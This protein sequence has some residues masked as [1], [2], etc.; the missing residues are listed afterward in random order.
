MPNL[1]IAAKIINYVALIKFFPKCHVALHVI[2]APWSVLKIEL[3]DPQ[4]IDPDT[5]NQCFGEAHENRHTRRDAR[6]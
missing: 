5:I 6:G 4:A 1:Q 3:D 2:I